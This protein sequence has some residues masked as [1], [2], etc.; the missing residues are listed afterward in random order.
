LGVKPEAGHGA[1]SCAP[2][3]AVMAQ[4]HS[5]FQCN[6]AKV[7]DG[8]RLGRQ[9]SA[10]CRH[11]GVSCPAHPPPA[12]MAQ[13]RQDLRA[14]ATPPLGALCVTGD[15]ASPRRRR[16]AVPRTSYQRA[17]PRRVRTRWRQ[18]R[19]ASSHC[20]ADLCW[21]WDAALSLQPHPVRQPRPGTVA[22]Q[23]VPGAPPARLAAALPQ[24]QSVCCRAPPSRPRRPGPHGLKVVPER[25]RVLGAH[26]DLGARGA[27]P[28]R[29]PRARGQPGVHGPQ[30]ART[31]AVAPPG[32]HPRPLLGRVLAGLWGQRHAHA[33]RQ[34][35]EARG[36]RGPRLRAAPP[37]LAL[38][39]AG[40]LA[41]RG[42]RRL[43]PA[44]RRPGPQ[45]GCDAL[46]LSPAHDGLEGGS[47]GRTRRH[48]SCWPQGGASMAP[49]RGARRLTPVASEPG[50]T[51]QG[52]DGHRRVALAV[53]MPDVR[54]LGPDL[55]HR[56]GLWSH[57]RSSS[58]AL[59][60]VGGRALPGEPARGSKRFMAPLMHLV[61]CSVAN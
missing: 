51:G 44:P 61:N 58:E 3:G 12:R 4:G 53:V 50:T 32:Q 21:L 54:A 22:H 48:A 7:Q 37:A 15:L 33:G 59:W 20:L 24:G 47:T 23:D 41:L 56:T 11:V 42:P 35:R 25:G 17:S 9:T 14:R 39:G 30:P 10:G 1:G 28:G 52:E 43:T 57:R 29:R 8:R 27:H 5:V 36:A 31:D 18:A 40:R 6:P 26:Q 55:A 16:L 2:A 45:R 38:A 13:R 49:P 19:D 46:P 34:R 60:L